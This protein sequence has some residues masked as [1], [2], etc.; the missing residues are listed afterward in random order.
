VNILIIV[1]NPKEQSLSFSIAK[2]YKEI[3]K[4]RGDNVE[5]IDLYRQKHQQPFFTNEALPTPQKEYFQSKISWADE[6]VFVFPYWWGSMPAILKNFI[7]WNFSSEFAFEYVNSRP[8][9]LLT[10]KSVK[11]FTTTGAP[12]F[13]YY[14][15]GAH[16]RLRGM[17]KAQIVEFCGMKLEACHIFGGVDTSLKDIDKIVEKI[18]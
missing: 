7:D 10:G 13:W 9:G 5:I 2:H 4:N 15:T 11:I 1:A 16:R 3:A 17:F 8:K 14:L 12:Y 6:L 18:R